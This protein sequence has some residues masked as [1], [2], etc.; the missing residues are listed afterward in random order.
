MGQ[1]HGHELVL[2]DARRL[3]FKHDAD[4]LL[5]A[6]FVAHAVE[7]AEHQ[8]LEVLLLLADVLLAGAGLRV[9]Q[10]F[11]LGQHLRHRNAMRQFIHNHAPL[12]ARQ[13][14]QSRF[15]TECLEQIA[16]ELRPD[17]RGRTQAAFGRRIQPVDTG[18]DGGLHRGGQADAGDVTRRNIVAGSSLKNTTLR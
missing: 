8:S 16:A 14:L 17:D 2:R 15:D 1:Q 9:G 7:Y 5:V 18:G 11:D 4:R 6:G 12:A 3:R 10:A 13:F